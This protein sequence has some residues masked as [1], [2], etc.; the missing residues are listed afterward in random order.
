M[1]ASMLLASIGHEKLIALAIKKGAGHAEP[2]IMKYLTD[3]EAMIIYYALKDDPATTQ[4]LMNLIPGRMTKF[5]VSTS[6]MAWKGSEEF[7]VCHSSAY[8]RAME[9]IKIPKPRPVKEVSRMFD[10]LL[11]RR[12][13]SPDSESLQCEIQKLIDRIEPYIFG[14]TPMCSALQDV[15][16]VFLKEIMTGPK[17]LFILSDGQSGDG[18]PREIAKRLCNSDVTIVTCFLTSDVLTN[19]R[20]LFDPDHHFSDYGKQT[21]F[22]MSSTMHNTHAPVS[23]LVDAG[24]ELPSCGESRLFIQANSLDVVNEFC[25]TLVSQLTKDCDAL[26][27]LLG[28]IP[29]ATYINQR[30]SEFEAKEQE[31]GTCYANAIAAVFHLAMSRI[32]G[33]D[34]G[35]PEFETIRDRLITEYGKHGANTERVLRNVCPEYRL[36][37][38]EVDETGARNAINKRRPVVAK[39]WLNNGAQWGKFSQFYR[40]TPKGILNKDDVASK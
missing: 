18:D 33:R 40:K 13:S 19:S 39:F 8:K 17:V 32:V 25:N 11:K 6:K 9:I 15:E 3:F 16:N 35:V 27:H 30:N 14:G 37:Y 28:K 31:G 4:E 7:A 38:N 26:V 2:W 34:G 5:L 29:L 20:C 36:R 24:W 12:K 22:E 1:Y 23:Y 21:L 10:N